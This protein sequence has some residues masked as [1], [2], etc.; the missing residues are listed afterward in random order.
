[1]DTNTIDYLLSKTLGRKVFRGV[2]SASALP[3]LEEHVDYPICMVVNTDCSHKLG[4]HW[5]SLYFD[6]LGVGRFFDSF[7]RLPMYRSWINYLSGNSKLGLWQFCKADIQPCNS[8]ACGEY[9]IYYLV[10]RHLTSLNVNDYSLMCDVTEY[11]VKKFV[12]NLFQ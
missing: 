6:S 3:V 12:Q 5:S 4:T 9:C 1:M 2:F 8:D 10:K 11:D 7:G